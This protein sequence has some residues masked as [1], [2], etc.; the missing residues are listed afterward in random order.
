MRHLWISYKDPAP[1]WSVCALVLGIAPSNYLTWR[2][3]IGQHACWGHV[4]CHQTKID[5]EQSD[6][7]ALQAVVEQLA[8]HTK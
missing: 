3:L 7:A 1:D 4:Q 8:C 2:S 5:M 6:W